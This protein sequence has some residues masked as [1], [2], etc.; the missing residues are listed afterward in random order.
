MISGPG[1]AAGPFPPSGNGSAPRCGHLDGFR[2]A[3]P[4]SAVCQACAAPPDRPVRPA[5]PDHPAPENRPGPQNRPARR[6]ILLACLTCG[7][8]ACSDDVPGHARAHY[9]ETD[10][11]VA[12]SLDRVSGWTWCYVHQRRI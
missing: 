5:S 10:H 2:P 4:G 11:P 9:E 7:W 8:V 6:A 12:R 3:A 1:L